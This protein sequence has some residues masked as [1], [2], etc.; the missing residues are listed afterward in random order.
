[1]TLEAANIQEMTDAELLSAAIKQSG[2]SV[3]QFSER[4]LIAPGLVKNQRTVW[5]WL[6]GENNL[7][8]KVRTICERILETA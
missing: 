2:L 4:V 5:R 6:A 7:P 1:M 3:R 8:E